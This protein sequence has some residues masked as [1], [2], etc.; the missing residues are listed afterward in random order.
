MA[1]LLLPLRPGMQ[2]AQTYQVGRWVSPLQGVAGRRPPTAPPLPPA[3]HA[4][5]PPGARHNA[6]WSAGQ[7]GKFE[8]QKRRRPGRTEAAGAC[9]GSTQSQ[10]RLASFNA[11]PC[12]KA[13]VLASKQAGQK[14][15][16]QTTQE[17]KQAG[18]QAS[19]CACIYR[20]LNP[21]PFAG[22]Q[23]GRF[24]RRLC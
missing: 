21:M 7:D 22:R 13:F 20:A 3:A 23:A 18:R 1:V 14:H 6:R 17:G 10:H 4:A 5:S 9:T 12:T 2:G 24:S 8:T 19:W 11:Q 16:R 15:T